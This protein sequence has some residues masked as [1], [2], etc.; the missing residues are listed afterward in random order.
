MERTYFYHASF[1]VLTSL[2]SFNGA[3]RETHGTTTT[4]VYANVEQLYDAVRA[5]IRKEHEC[6]R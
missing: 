1:T 2:V 3:P 5:A 4:A 6:M